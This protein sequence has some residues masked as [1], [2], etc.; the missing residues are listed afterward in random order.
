MSKKLAK[1]DSTTC[2]LFLPLM[3]KNVGNTLLSCFKCDTYEQIDSVLQFCNF[4]N[5]DFLNLHKLGRN[6]IL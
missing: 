3:L 4:R 2:S 5:L 6:L 1:F